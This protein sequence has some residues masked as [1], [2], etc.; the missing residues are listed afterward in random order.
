MEK[1]SV[2]R[3]RKVYYKRWFIVPG[4]ITRIRNAVYAKAYGDIAAI[5][6]LAE[7]TDNN[8]EILPMHVDGGTK[9]AKVKRHQ[10]GSLYDLDISKDITDAMK[11]L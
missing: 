8:V 3:Q 1:L 2:V 9:I 7:S 4:R 11:R 10:K 6:K 5:E